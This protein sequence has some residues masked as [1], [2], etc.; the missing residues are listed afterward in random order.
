MTEI[1]VDRKLYVSFRQDSKS[2]L[3][4]FMSLQNKISKRCTDSVRI[5]T[6]AGQDSKRLPA[7]LTEEKS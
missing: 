4:Y 2:G 6:P 3:R 5:E 1:P 7:I